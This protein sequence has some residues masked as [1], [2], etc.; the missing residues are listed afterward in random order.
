MNKSFSSMDIAW[1]KDRSDPQGQRYRLYHP[2][3]REMGGMISRLNSHADWFTLSGRSYRLLRDAK[4]AAERFE[5]RSML[6]Q[7]ERLSDTMRSSSGTELEWDK[8]SLYYLEQLLDDVVTRSFHT[9]VQSL[10]NPVFRDENHR[11]GSATSA[12]DIAGDMVS[13]LECH[14]PYRPVGNKRAFL[15]SDIGCR[16]TIN[17][18][19]EGPVLQSDKTYGEGGV[20]RIVLTSL[21]Q[22]DIDIA[23]RNEVVAIG[24]RYG[25]GE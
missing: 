14:I 11:L 25:V 2:Y 9:A 18:D 10:F 1:R 22:H 21:C 17:R 20:K 23:V 7:F 8:A 19:I 13:L 16:F 15:T 4:P 3:Y 12:F 5:K 24:K 6:V